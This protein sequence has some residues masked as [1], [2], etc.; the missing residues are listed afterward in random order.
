[1]NM[2]LVSGEEKAKETSVWWT[3]KSDKGHCRCASFIAKLSCGF[4]AISKL[5]RPLLT[6]LIR[7]LGKSHSLHNVCCFLFSWPSQYAVCALFVWETFLWH[8]TICR[9]YYAHFGGRASG[10]TQ[11]MS[12]PGAMALRHLENDSGGGLHFPRIFYIPPLSMQLEYV[13]IRG[14]FLIPVE[15]S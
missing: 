13:G 4:V 7:S 15:K 9:N 3:M 11:R 2:C 5:P 6:L 14:L 8:L 1:M 10:Q 12:S